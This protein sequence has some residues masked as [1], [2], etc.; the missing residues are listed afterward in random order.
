MTHSYLFKRY[1]DVH[2]HAPGHLM[3][4]V[5]GV[6]F[7]WYTDGQILVFCNTSEMLTDF[8]DEVVIDRYF[9]TQCSQVAQHGLSRRLGNAVSEWSDGCV[10]VIDA[11]FHALDID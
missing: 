1:L 8:V 11:E 5:A 10:N 3:M 6:I 2:H 9:I 7:Q 4:I